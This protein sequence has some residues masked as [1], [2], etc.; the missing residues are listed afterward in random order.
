MK[1]QQKYQEMCLRQQNY[2]HMKTDL[3]YSAGTVAV[4]PTLPNESELSDLCAK[5]LIDHLLYVIVVA[6][7]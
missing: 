5:M 1:V 2:D 7:L 3:V 4:R 6:C